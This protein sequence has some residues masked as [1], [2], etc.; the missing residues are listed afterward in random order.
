MTIDSHSGS[1][2]LKVFKSEELCLALS[3]Y[4][5]EHACCCLQAISKEFLSKKTAPRVRRALHL[6]QKLCDF[7]AILEIVLQPPKQLTLQEIR[8]EFE[9]SPVSFSDEQLRQV[10]TKAYDLFIIQELPCAA[11]ALAK[12]SAS[13][14]NSRAPSGLHSRSACF[15][16]TLASQT[17]ALACPSQ[18]HVPDE[19]GRFLTAKPGGRRLS[20]QSSVVVPKDC[21]VANLGNRMKAYQS[22]VERLHL[23]EN[24][25][26]IAEAAETTRATLAALFAKGD[27][28]T[29][30]Q[31]HRYLT[32]QQSK[33]RC[34]QRVSAEQVPMALLL[35]MRRSLEGLSI[36]TGRRPS[37]RLQPFQGLSAYT[38]K[39]GLQRDL[40][41][42]EWKRRRLASD[43]KHAFTATLPSSS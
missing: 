35:L 33:H 34:G 12:Q 19:I 28:V 25:I 1:H 26:S 6:R 3:S 10:L 9:C 15:Q 24:W 40:E 21:P 8:E 38:S 27:N 32:A 36:E 31:I 16:A 17:E 43:A 20:R 42:L 29:V 41:I 2:L 7:F 37:L 23:C 30:D 13:T 14:N 18:P 22:A 39:R 5:E 11:L 4:L